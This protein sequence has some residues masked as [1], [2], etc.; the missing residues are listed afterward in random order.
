MNTFANLYF[1]IPRRLRFSIIFAFL[2]V[3]AYLIFYLLA[4]NSKT[5]EVPN[6]FLKARQEASLIAQDIISFS[7]QTAN[8]I[9]KI[10]EL[11]K[12]AK[13]EDALNLI[14]KEIE[15]NRQARERAISLSAQLEKMTKN[16]SGIEPPE[17]AQ[18]A[19]QA[20]GSETTLISRLISYNDY[21]V[22]FLEIL[23]QKFSKDKN[24]NGRIAELVGKIN[25][26]SKTINN[27]DKNFNQL[28]AE[29][30]KFR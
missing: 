17:A 20:V 18:I 16:I 29:F 21:L 19:L 14:T 6:E 9:S 2:I 3:A 26:E 13:Y 27:L 23:R 24:T 30:D 8:N 5:K 7:N 28:M 10:S 1:K 22:Q 11:D 4:A 25:E 15:Y 12:E